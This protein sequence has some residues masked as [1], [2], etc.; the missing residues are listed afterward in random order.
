VCVT[1]IRGTNPDVV[2][3]VRGGVHWSVEDIS[4]M[5]VKAMQRP[6]QS[7]YQII[8][9]EG[10]E[11]AIT[12]I[13]AL[14]KI[15]EE[16]PTKTI[17]IV[18]GEANVS[19]LDTIYSRCVTVHLA[20]LSREALVATLVSEGASTADAE[21]AADAANGDLRRAR[22][23]M[24][25]DDVARRVALWR[26]VPDEV[27][28][29]LSVSMATVRTLLAAI[30]EALAPLITVQD[31][32]YQQLV[33]R[34]KAMGLRPEMSKKEAD[35]VHKREQRK[36]RDEEFRFGLAALT[37]VYRERLHSSVESDDSLSRA[38]VATSSR[39]IDAV[40]QA[41]RRL[42][43]NLDYEALLADLVMEL[44]SL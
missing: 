38:R 2:V 41:H 9:F 11:L 33:T 35:V 32:E 14:L 3:P 42:D 23:L 27:N 12:A 7:K 1:T 29:E 21:L 39:A 16:P 34:A 30:D 19:E 15:I 6:L 40:A 44:A 8:I 10:A 36:F 37:G 26:G 31:E 28:G 20:A 22:V 13:P 18:T 5:G 24:R 43:T 17:F 25:D 4:D